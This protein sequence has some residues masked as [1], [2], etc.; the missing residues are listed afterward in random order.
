[1]SDELPAAIMVVDDNDFV[2]ETT[3]LL[4][5]GYGFNVY[6]F[7]SAE[8][9]LSNAAGLGG[10]RFD[11]VVTDIKMP[12]ITGIE[13]LE[14][15]HALDQDLPVILMT[16]YAELDVAIDAIKKGAFDFLIKPFK[17]EYLLHAVK[18]AVNYRRLVRMEKDYKKRLEEDVAKRTRELADALALVKNVSNEMAERITTIA[19]FRDIETGAHIKRIGVYAGRVAAALGM[20]A[21]EIET[22]TFASSLHDIGKIGIPDN[23]LLKPGPLTKEEF[24][25]MKTHTAI[26][27]KMLSGSEYA[28]LQKA[29]VIALNHHERWDGGGYPRGLKGAD[30]PLEGRI[31]MLVDQYDALRSK[32]PYK[33]AFGH[34]E[35]VRIITQGDGRTMPSH[36]D[37]KLLE[38]FNGLEKD[39]EKIFEEHQD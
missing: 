36:F 18:K 4:L 34:K 7:L 17:P 3:T 1:M 23:V 30:T 37:P 38:V 6:G 35:T 22:I 26:G 31:V 24:D 29:A 13:L 10:A 20:T 8:D 27:E 39:F 12:K 15:L 11:A 21:E 9:A 16:A 33:N 5:Q 32:R 28:S 25:V 2:L 14:R 19:E